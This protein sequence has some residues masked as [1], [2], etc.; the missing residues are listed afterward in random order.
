MSS[1][2][3]NAE[4]VLQEEIL[5]DARRQ[6]KEAVDR[7]RKEAEAILQKA[8]IDAEN[9]R[10][11]QAQGAEAEAKRRKELALATIPVTVGRRRAEC[12][13]AALNQVRDEAGRGLAARDGFDYRQAVIRLTAKAIAQMDGNRFV[14]EVSD[15][16]NQ[17]LG[18]GW[19]EEVCRQAGRSGLELSTAPAKTKNQVGVLVRDA[20]GRQVW[21]NT[22]PARLERL[23]PAL[24][25][26]LAVATRLVSGAEPQ[27]EVKSRYT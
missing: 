20:E 16:D 18:Q 22:L 27:I 4:S 7:A 12:V 8:R 14:L 17:A 3:S 23:W 6:A 9:D 11:V 13:E 2:Q 15:A 5:A 25:R 1:A 21:D 24:R 26:D 10:R 19:L